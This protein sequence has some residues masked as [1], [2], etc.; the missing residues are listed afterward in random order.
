MDSGLCSFTGDAKLYTYWNRTFV[1]FGLGELL[2]TSYLLQL[3][4]RVSFP[5]SK[6][7]KIL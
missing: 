5:F 7:S 3:W 4:L 1:V 2:E 6:K